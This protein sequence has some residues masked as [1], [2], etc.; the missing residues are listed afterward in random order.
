MQRLIKGRR[1]TLEKEVE[2][3]R[4]RSAKKALRGHGRSLRKSAARLLQKRRRGQPSTAVGE[5]VDTAAIVPESECG[6]PQGGIEASAPFVPPD[7]DETAPAP[8]PS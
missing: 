7:G 6:L 8:P 4:L 1:T 2:G 3:R 5:A